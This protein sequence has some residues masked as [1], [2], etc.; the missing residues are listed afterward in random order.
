MLLMHNDIMSFPECL[1][2]IFGLLLFVEAEIALETISVPQ[3]ILG[4]VL[5]YREK[6]CDLRKQPRLF[7]DGEDSRLTLR[8][9]TRNE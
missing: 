4:L 1:T 2:S 5:K 9:A 3:V 7:R 6:Q 8:L